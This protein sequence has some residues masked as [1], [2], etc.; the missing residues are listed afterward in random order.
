MHGIS[1]PELHLLLFYKTPI[2]KQL[3]L[4]KVAKQLSGLKLFLTFINIIKTT[5]SRK[6]EFFL[7]NKRK[8][9]AITPQY[10]CLKSIIGKI[11][12]LLILNI[13]FES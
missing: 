6:V 10:S 13:N 7:C 1:L 3:A 5:D 9:A 2:Y 11:L 4:G 8:K 12:K